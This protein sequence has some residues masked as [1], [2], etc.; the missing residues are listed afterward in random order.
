MSWALEYEDFEQLN[1][2]IKSLKDSEDQA[3]I[4]SILER[5]SIAE[6]KVMAYERVFLKKEGDS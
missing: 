2:I 1:K 6:G 3:F 4:L 5:L